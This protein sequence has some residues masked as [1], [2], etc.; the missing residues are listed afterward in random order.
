[1]VRLKDNGDNKRTMGNDKTTMRD[2]G[3]L[4]V[5]F[6]KNY[7]WEEDIMKTSMHEVGIL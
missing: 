7:K 1:M 3:I 6:F 2:N 5:L 4:F